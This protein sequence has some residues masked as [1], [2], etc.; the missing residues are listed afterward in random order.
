MC[1]GGTGCREPG[2]R[3]GVGGG[4][5]NSPA[6]TTAL[7]LSTTPMQPLERERSFP[8]SRDSASSHRGTA[9]WK[10][11]ES[12]L[13]SWMGEPQGQREETGVP[14]EMGAMG[15]APACPCSGKSEQCRSKTL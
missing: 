4:E 8:H 10:P 13:G 12:P 2:S 15:D 3:P 5:P 14:L 1:R 11:G 6:M 7:G 9:S